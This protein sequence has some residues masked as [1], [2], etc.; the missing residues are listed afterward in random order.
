[1]SRLG[2]WVVQWLSRALEAAE[3]DAVCGDL[4][5]SGDGAACALRGVLG[6]VVRRQVVFWRGWQTWVAIALGFLLGVISRRESNR[7]AIYIWLYANNW[8]WSYVANA[9]FLRDLVVVVVGVCE[10]FAVLVLC[11]WLA[12]LLLGP[13]ACRMTWIN[14][15]LLCFILSIGVFMGPSNNGRN[16]AVFA[17]VFYRLIFPLIVQTVLV[18]LPAVWVCGWRRAGGEVRHYC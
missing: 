16:A 6:L 17:G 8:T 13:L 7:S 5:E 10:E 1:M 12:G 11:S 2:W 4:V 9:G 18:V 14:G 3:R 15:T